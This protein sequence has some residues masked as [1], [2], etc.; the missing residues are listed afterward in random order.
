MVIIGAGGAGLIGALVA[1]SR[2]ARV[3]LLERNRKAGIKLLISGGGKC[4][5]THEGTEEEIL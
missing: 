1:A 5:V 4:N 2:G 3:L